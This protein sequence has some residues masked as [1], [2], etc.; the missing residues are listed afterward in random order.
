MT[1]YNIGGNEEENA[2]LKKL[3]AD[4]VWISHHE[5][6]TLKE[7]DADLETRPKTPI[8]SIIGR[9]SFV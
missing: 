3:N 1:D 9:S 8:I 5:T 7:A 2:E 6:H 4:V